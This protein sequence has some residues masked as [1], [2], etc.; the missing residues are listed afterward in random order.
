MRQNPEVTV[1]PVE[2][3]SV[4][5]EKPFAVVVRGVEAA[6]GVFDSAQI[7]TQ[8]AEGASPT[9]IRDAINAMA[10]GSGFMRFA[11]WDHGFL[12]RQMGQQSE[13]VRFVIGHPLIATRMTRRNIGAGL[14]APLS[15][16]V[17]GGERGG[18]RLEYDR[19]S[20]LLKPFDDADIASVGLE[21][22]EKLSALVQSVAGV[23]V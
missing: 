11:M 14:Y 13:A 20:T 16:L 1:N 12:L 21:L 6:T 4:W 7:Q 17:V 15:L 9:V 23:C 5:T 22:D 8:V 3:I 2:H 10:G 18:T 19:P